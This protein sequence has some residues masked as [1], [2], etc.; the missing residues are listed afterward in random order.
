MGFFGLHGMNETAWHKEML[1]YIGW[2]MW[3]AVHQA[4]TINRA[5]QRSEI[6]L[7]V[8]DQFSKF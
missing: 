8:K 3:C 6:Y 5:L 4:F 7:L 1:C 2:H